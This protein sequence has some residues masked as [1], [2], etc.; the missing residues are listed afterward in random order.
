MILFGPTEWYIKPP[1]IIAI[2]KPKNHIEL[3]KPNCS[4]VKLNSSASCGKMP[5]LRLNEKAVVIKAKQL[6]RKSL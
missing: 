5:A 3:I 6:P 2:G 1:T 4:P